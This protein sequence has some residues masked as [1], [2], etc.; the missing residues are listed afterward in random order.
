[1][2][3]KNVIPMIMVIMLLLVLLSVIYKVRFLKIYN[4]FLAWVDVK[5]ENKASR[6]GAR[7]DLATLSDFPRAASSP[8]FLVCTM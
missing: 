6:N 3:H 4:R 5:E 8:V 1:M 7:T 2:L